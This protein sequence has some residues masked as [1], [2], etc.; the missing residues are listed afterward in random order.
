MQ[1][2]S[3]KLINKILNDHLLCGSLLFWGRRLVSIGTKKEKIFL[4]SCFGVVNEG[5]EVV[6]G[7]P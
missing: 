1:R 7:D 2:I 4:R 6:L 5:E 3:R